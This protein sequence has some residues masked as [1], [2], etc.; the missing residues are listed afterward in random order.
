MNPAWTVG[1]IRMDIQAMRLSFPAQAPVFRHL[2]RPDIHR[3][4]VLLY[5]ICGWSAG[6]IAKRY[7]IGRK[8]VLQMIRQWT[9]RAIDLGYI[10]RIPR[11]EE[12]I[13][14]QGLQKPG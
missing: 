2:H 5:F 14:D 7:G 6:A 4:V 1:R 8:R 10:A 3:R 9:L 11:K 12:C 13:G